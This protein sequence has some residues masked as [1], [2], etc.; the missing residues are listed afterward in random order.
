MLW[1]S[2]RDQAGRTLVM[3]A[4]IIDTE[5]LWGW[6]LVGDPVPGPSPHVAAYWDAI[7]WSLSRQLSCDFGGAPTAGIRSFKAAMGGETELCSVA[8]RVRPKAYRQVRTLH[9]RLSDYRAKRQE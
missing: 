4:S 1:R 5:R 8:E 3:N 9:A 7:Q 2:V 6:L